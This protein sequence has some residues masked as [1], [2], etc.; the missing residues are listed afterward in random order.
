M[1]LT[2]LQ[3]QQRLTNQPSPW[4][5]LGAGLAAGVKGFMDGQEQQ[6]ARA[7]EAEQLRRQ[8][9]MQ[10]LQMEH[11][12]QQMANAKEDQAMQR[13]AKQQTLLGNLARTN[14][15]AAMSFYNE[16]FLPAAKDAGMGA[17]LNPLVGGTRNVT[18]ADLDDPANI[19]RMMGTGKGMIMPTGKADA[20]TQRTMMGAAGV[21]PQAPKYEQR[22]P[23]LDTYRINPD[24]TETFV[25]GAAQKPTDPLARERFEE[26][27]RHNRTM[28]GLAGDNLT[29]RRENA[30]NP[31]QQRLTHEDIVA[32]I[33]ERPRVK[34]DAE[35]REDARQA[36]NQRLPTYSRGTPQWDKAY[37][38]ELA[39]QRASQKDAQTKFADWQK[40]YKRL[41][42]GSQQ[43]SG[44]GGDFQSWFGSA[45][46]RA[47]RLVSGK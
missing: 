19:D 33:G 35:I 2:L 42:S 15:D 8:Q 22:D 47:E 31:R 7:L 32:E 25:R 1:L 5:N 45:L 39:A 37:A 13:F 10:D 34:T 29:L 23:Y 17:G 44:A 43:Q 12:R 9:A 20:T 24:G 16:T 41:K 4:Q 18:M 26:T 40:R 6:R 27:Q 14:P 38:E 28:E 11:T 36:T 30:S 21:T 3:E 46:E